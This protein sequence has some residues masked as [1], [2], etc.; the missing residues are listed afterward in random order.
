MNSFSRKIVLDSNLLV[1]LVVGLTDQKLISKH[2]RT[3]TFEQAD[4]GLLVRTISRFDTIILTPHVL[5]EVSNLISQ[6]S[7]PALS[8]VRTTFAN[9]IQIQ[10]EVYV[11][12]KDSVRQSSFI[13]LGL[14]DAAILELVSTD[15]ALLTTDVGLY[16]EAAKTNPLAENFNHLRQARLLDN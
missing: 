8:A 5:T 16:L 2:K 1:L 4:F 10:E 12:S 9:F 7:E 3:K 15:L 14:T 11:F 13:R 6:T